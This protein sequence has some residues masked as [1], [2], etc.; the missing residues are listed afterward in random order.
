MSTEFVKVRHPQRGDADITP[1]EVAYYRTMGFEPVD[2]AAAKAAGAGQPE[3][4]KN[5]LAPSA[6]GTDQRLDLVLDELRGLRSDLAG[7]RTALTPVEIEPQ[8]GEPIE[9]K[10]PATG[11]AA[12]AANSNLT[13]AS[14]IKAEDDTVIAQARG[15][16]APDTAATADPAK[17]DKA[18]TKP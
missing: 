12:L 16:G 8:D 17:A 9:L 18:K 4:A 3:P 2:P 7:I 6:N 14:D 11:E 10:E 5:E 15:T 13:G 1:G